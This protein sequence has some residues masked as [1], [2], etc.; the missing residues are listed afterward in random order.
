MDNQKDNNS[1][2]KDNQANHGQLVLLSNSTVSEGR[3]SFILKKSEKLAA[4]LYRLTEL[5]SDRDEIKWDIRELSSR[6]VADLALE[7]ISRSHNKAS[8][9]YNTGNALAALI[10][11]C[12][13]CEIAG[14][15]SPM[16]FG[17]IRSE[18]ENLIKMIMGDSVEV[19]NET[20]SIQEMLAVDED[21]AGTNGHLTPL[22]V[23]R[24]VGFSRAGLRASATSNGVNNNKKTDREFLSSRQELIVRYIKK[25]GESGIKDITPHIH[26]CSEKTI[27]R[28]LVRLVELGVLARYGER[29]WSRYSLIIGVV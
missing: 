10:S 9:L 3:Y 12:A 24:P 11:L 26:G 22:E 28:D 8:V 19:E 1:Y 20:V 6:I 16:N 4:V 2:N 23:A 5:I 27:Q 29:R 21:Y 13:V 15:I 17:V 14:Y 7:S 18:C 25:N